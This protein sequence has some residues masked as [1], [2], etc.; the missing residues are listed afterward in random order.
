[1]SPLST[2]SNALTHRLQPSTRT[3]SSGHQIPNILNDCLQNRWWLVTRLVQP[4]DQPRAQVSLPPPSL[5]R[6]LFTSPSCNPHI[7]PLALLVLEAWGNRKAESSPPSRAPRE[8]T[9][10]STSTSF[11]YPTYTSISVLADIPLYLLTANSPS[12]SAPPAPASPPLYTSWGCTSHT[13]EQC[14][15][16]T[17]TTSTSTPRGC[18]ETGAAHNMVKMYR[19]RCEVPNCTV[20]RIFYGLSHMISTYNRTTG[21]TVTPNGT[22]GGAKYQM[23]CK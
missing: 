2:I 21:P 4:V 13:T 11:S 17:L 5:L 14:Y 23:T 1:M 16:M 3:P 8:F 6:P 12:L 18:G 10:S 20:V 19:R 7:G 15:S 9:L 22:D